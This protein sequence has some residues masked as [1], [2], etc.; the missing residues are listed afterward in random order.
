M[1]LWDFYERRAVWHFKPMHHN[2]VEALA[3][4]P[5]DKYLVS[6]GGQDDGRY[7]FEII[8]IVFI[9]LMQLF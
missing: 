1:Y 3:I 9:L 7:I 4:S 5:S 8:I 2:K 6:L